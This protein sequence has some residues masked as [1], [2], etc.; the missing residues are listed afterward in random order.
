MRVAMVSVDGSGQPN[1]VSDLVMYRTPTV[2]EAGASA[3][4]AVRMESAGGRVESDGTIRGTRWTTVGVDHPDREEDEIPL[5]STPGPLGDA[6]AAALRALAVELLR[7]GGGRVP[8]WAVG[9]GA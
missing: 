6:E 8:G 1:G 4:V 3:P 7:R 2:A 9:Q 5:D